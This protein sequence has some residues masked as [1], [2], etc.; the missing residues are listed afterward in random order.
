M[1]AAL[2]LLLFGRRRLLPSGTEGVTVLDAVFR[3]LA[4]DASHAVAAVESRYFVEAL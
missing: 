2:L 4:V 1:T 3:T